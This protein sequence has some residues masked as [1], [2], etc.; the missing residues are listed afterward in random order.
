MICGGE[1]RLGN[2][3]GDHFSRE[4][5]EP[6]APDRNRNSLGESFRD[7]TGGAL[8]AKNEEY[9]SLKSLDTL[10]SFIQEFHSVAE[11]EQAL[12]EIFKSPEASDAQKRLCEG[13]F[14]RLFKFAAEELSALIAWMN[15]RHPEALGRVI[16]GNQPYDAEIKLAS[17][18]SPQEIE[19]GAAIDGYADQLLS[20][21]ITENG[22][23]SP[24]SV[25]ERIGKGAQKTV[26]TKNN[27]ITASS[28][29]L[30]EKYL[31][32][33]ETI[34]KKK[35]VKKY[36]SSTVIVLY[37]DSHTA[38]CGI[39]LDRLRNG[40]K[41]ILDNQDWQVTQVDVICLKNGLLATKAN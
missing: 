14:G 35:S 23:G 27:R 17:D 21:A 30:V 5:A 36:A 38:L 2:D 13:E 6:R 4:R 3:P 7:A 37:L 16:D 20:E 26:G 24:N 31:G 10:K 9:T 19:F 29:A 39:E 41:T 22:H 8:G 18:S 34:A 40:A 33:I 32:W 25:Y 12:G 11:L 15:I 1:W 28:K